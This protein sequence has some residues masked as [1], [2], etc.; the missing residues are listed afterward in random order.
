M[1]EDSPSFQ[2][3]VNYIGWVGYGNV[4]DEAI[5]FAIQ[6]AFSKYT[7][8]PISRYY[9]SGITIFG[10]GTLLPVWS[11]FIMPNTYN[12]GYGLGVADP[13]F[14]EY[15]YGPK[16]RRFYE[17]AIMKTLNV[18]F[19]MIGVRGYL[20]KRILSEWGL[21]S[22]NIGDPCLLFKPNVNVKRNEKLV[23]VN[24]GSS[25]N[26]PIW[27]NDVNLVLNA[28]EKFCG[29]I[30][31]EGYEVRLVVFSESDLPHNYKLASKL[32]LPILKAY[33]NEIQSTVNFFSS[34][35][36]I[37]GER[38]H[39]IVLSATTYTPFISLEYNTKCLEFAENMEFQDYQI[40]TSEIDYTILLELFEKLIDRW[41]SLHDK[42]KGKVEYFRGR[43][44]DF[45]SR[46]INDVENLPKN[47]WKSPGKWKQIRFNLLSK[48]ES[49]TPT[50]SCRLERLKRKLLRGI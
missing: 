46:V 3:I 22:E 26:E 10:G 9:M 12:Y 41:P 35:K 18:N 34:C 8:V 20:S 4:G 45:T 14:F 17:Y 33:K 11:T 31:R 36:A 13:E 49:K 19:R 23:A 25:I 42:L 21:E 40:R 44:L 5:Y 1:N 50:I 38:L 16:A 47:K 39:S 30:K 6:N 48:I 43:L 7:L 24:V 2:K 28:I 29:E 37:I 15:Q 32:N 27:G